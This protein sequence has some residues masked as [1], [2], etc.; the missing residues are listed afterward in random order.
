MTKK[1]KNL[2]NE[3]ASRI[4]DVKQKEELLQALNH[5]IEIL[6]DKISNAKEQL[7]N[8]EK[9]FAE[10]RA[11]LEQQL[12]KEKKT[13]KEVE[14][15]LDEQSEKIEKLEK[16]RKLWEKERDKEKRPVIPQKTID[17]ASPQ[18]KIVHSEKMVELMKALNYL[19]SEN[20]KLKAKLAGM[21]IL[22]LG[23]DVFPKKDPQVKQF[24]F[25]TSELLEDV[26]KHAASGTVINLSF[27]SRRMANLFTAQRRDDL[28]LMKMK[29]EEIEERVKTSVSPKLLKKLAPTTLS[30][31]FNT[32]KRI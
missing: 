21:D 29:N 3:L 11:K 28:A 16:E 18:D 14:K 24:L 15:K 9:R 30:M 10:D 7:V 19:R 32:I 27:V 2:S 26:Q 31:N 1:I 23:K 4:T 22:S 13:S 6:E 20:S 12:E 17:T 25:E 5:K 8:E